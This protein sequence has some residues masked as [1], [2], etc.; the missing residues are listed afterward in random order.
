[1]L[2]GRAVVV[3]ASIAGLFAARALS[4]FFQSV[5]VLDSDTLDTGTVPRKAVPQ[6]NHIHAILPPAHQSLKRL[7]PEVIEKL[8][9]GGA[10]VFDGGKDIKWRHLGHWLVRGETGQT[11][12]GRM[13]VNS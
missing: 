9:A 7:M 6:G 8:L 11:F 5:I 1:M 2:A 12:I 13:S 10:H 4:D 3:G